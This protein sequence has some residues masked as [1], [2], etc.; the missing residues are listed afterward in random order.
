MA[1][2]EK[3]LGKEAYKFFVKNYDLGDFVWVEGEMFTTHQGETSVLVKKYQ[4]LSK[5]LLPPC[6]KNFMVYGLEMH[7]RQRYLDL[8]A[9]D[10]SIQ[11]PNCAAHWLSN[12][13]IFC[14]RGFLKWKPRCFQTRSTAAL[15]P[16]LL[17][18]TITRLTSHFTRIA[19]TLFKTPVGGRV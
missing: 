2:S 13:V 1:F 16:A 19:G 15:T 6:P 4:L 12:C 11:M 17:S 10:E 14:A 18:R 3:E 8:I 9:N 5:A 7:Y